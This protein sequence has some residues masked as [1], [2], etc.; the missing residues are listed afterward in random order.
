ME[1]SLTLVVPCGLQL[2]KSP[3]DLV[4]LASIRKRLQRE[5]AGIDAKLKQG[6][7][8]QLDATREA[9][10]KLRESKSQIEAIKE[11]M[12]IIEKACE[13]PRVHVDGFGSCVL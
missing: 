7:K 12:V 13:D 2:F 4:K 5:Q 6:A 3:D 10:S 1:R 8:E 9:M 11:E